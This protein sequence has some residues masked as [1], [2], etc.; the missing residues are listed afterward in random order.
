MSLRMGGLFS[1]IGGFELAATWCGMSV[2]FV[3]EIEPYCCALLSERFPGVPNLGD[4]TTIDW[5]RAPRV[6]VLC[7]GFPCQDISNAGKRA[8]ITGA[9]SGLWREYARAIRELRPRFVLV[10]NVRALTQ[11]GLPVVLG[12]LASLGYDAEWQVLSAADVGAPHKR[13]RLWIVAYANGDRQR[14]PEGRIVQERG[15]LGDS[16]ED[17][18]DANDSGRDGR[19]GEQWASGRRESADGG[20]ALPDTPSV[21]RGQDGDGSQPRALGEAVPDAVR[22]RGQLSPVWRLPTVE[23]ARRD[24]T[25]RSPRDGSAWWAVEPD[26]GRVAHG[27]PARVDRLRGLGNAIVPQCAVPFLRRF[28]T[29]AEGDAA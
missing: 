28:Q 4:V 29:L 12:D 1:G 7:G 24:G 9:R 6:D 5:S 17:V 25:A 18:A 21:R 14:Q 26:V 16:G 20:E 22:E 27:V 23:G 11:R 10:E 19:S 15:R 13:D 3:A 2:E 8:G